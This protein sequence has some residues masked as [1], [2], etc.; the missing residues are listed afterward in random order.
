MPDGINREEITLA[1]E[2]LLLML[3]DFL[4]EHYGAKERD[5]LLL[6]GWA[7]YI[8]AGGERSEDI[9]IYV[10]NKE[11][12]DT[13]RATIEEIK[14][15]IRSN[16]IEEI[17]IDFFN[18]ES[19]FKYMGLDH[20]DLRNTAKIVEY[21]GV[22]FPIVD[23]TILVAMKFI[24]A[25]GRGLGTQRGIRKSI[26]D[27]ND[28]FY[29]MESDTIHVNIPRVKRYL[30]KYILGK[31]KTY[32][33]FEELIENTLETLDDLSSFLY[34]ED[35]RETLNLVREKYLEVRDEIKNI[36]QFVWG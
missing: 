9:D 33:E 4:D 20:S 18:S 32:I 29:L 16:H 35:Q 3:F 23:P 30:K 13:I 34:D 15:K 28:I 21:G 5:Y 11:L 17:S 8:Y 1:S 25:P 10:S 26:K 27:I 12:E 22:R 14:P 2:K 31:S 7:V 36:K 19:V 24:S 6:G